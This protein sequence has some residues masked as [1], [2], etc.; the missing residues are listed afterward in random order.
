[1]SP[2]INIYQH[3]HSSFF[4]NNFNKIITDIDI[5][6]SSIDLNKI[7]LL[8]LPELMESQLFVN[9]FITL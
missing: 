1:M 5:F 6:V 4:R 9:F 2:G 8:R 3:P 7:K